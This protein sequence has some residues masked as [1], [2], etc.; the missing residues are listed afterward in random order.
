MLPVEDRASLVLELKDR[1]V[2][3]SRET[4]EDGTL[5][6]DIGP[7]TAAVPLEERE[8][9]P[10]TPLVSRL[11]IQETTTPDGGRFLRL[12]IAPRGIGGSSIRVAGNRVYIDLSPDGTRPSTGMALRE[13][14]IEPAGAVAADLGS[15]AGGAPAR[16]QAPAGR[17]LPAGPLVAAEVLHRASLLAAKPDVRNLER[18]HE[19]L[20]TRTP[21]PDQPLSDETR[22]MMDEVDRYLSEARSL[23]LQRD[24]RDFE[25]VEFSRY[26][27]A[28]QPILARLERLQPDLI[29]AARRPAPTEET[30]RQLLA[31]ANAEAGLRAI[32]VPPQLVATHGRV[33]SALALATDALQHPGEDATRKI[34]EAAALLNWARTDLTAPP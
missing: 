14:I 26:R 7:V 33:Q 17:P 1:G 16:A 5:T 25:R 19:E 13:R 2:K 24:A 15:E 4:A 32:A 8:A 27:R 20:L 12:R 10:D 31:L 28:V 22:R 18:L 3:A 30:G 29:A 23:Q 21:Q 6:V 9:A 11:S 34:T